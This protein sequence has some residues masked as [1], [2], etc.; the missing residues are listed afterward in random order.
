[1]SFQ[2]K[3]TKLGV[4]QGFLEGKFQVWY[5]TS[6]APEIPIYCFRDLEEA[7]LCINRIS[8]ELDELAVEGN[9]FLEDYDKTLG[10]SLKREMEDILLALRAMPEGYV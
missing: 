3:H 9:V 4:F 5:P 10:D 1:M 6:C 7:K 2:I 8:S